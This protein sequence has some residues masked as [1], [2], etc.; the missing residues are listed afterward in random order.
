MAM[1][2]DAD[3]HKL[4]AAAWR[5]LERSNFETCKV[6][7]VMKEAGVSAR[8]FY[9]YFADKDQLLLALMSDEMARSSRYLAAAVA[10]ADGP[11]ERVGAWIA[12]VIGAAGDPRRSARARLF[13]SQQ[14]MT[15]KY[16]EEIAEGT[17]MLTA[18]LRAALIDGQADGTFPWADP[19]RD[20]SLIYSLAGGQMSDALSEAVTPDIAERTAATIALVLR[21]LG[22]APGGR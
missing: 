21:S 3:A 19:D 4:L 8:T 14:P 16:P 2:M 11:A 15:R 7:R 12:A 6:E 5:V 10:A 9:R 1:G 22:V 17:A 20:T 13:S 18:P